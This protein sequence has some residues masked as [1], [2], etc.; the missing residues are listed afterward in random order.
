LIEWI[1]ALDAI[2]EEFMKYKAYMSTAPKFLGR[3]NLEMGLGGW[4]RLFAGI[5][6]V[7]SVA[8]ES[9]LGEPMRLKR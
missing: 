3:W 2:V 8:E 7:G 9:E 5:T 6:G 1:Y 4:P